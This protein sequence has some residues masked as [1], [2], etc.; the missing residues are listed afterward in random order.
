MEHF[1]NSS[2]LKTICRSLIQNKNWMEVCFVPSVRPHR[3]SYYSNIIRKS[4]NRIKHKTLDGQKSVPVNG[5]CK[6]ELIPIP[7]PD[8][9]WGYFCQRFC[10]CFY[11]NCP[12]NNTIRRATSIRGFHGHAYENRG[13]GLATLLQA[14]HALLC[15]IPGLLLGEMWSV[16]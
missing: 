2:S 1:A 12:L 3:Q 15:P 5:S 10:C 11:F 14:Y 7:P 4:K 8:S 9:S 6:A 16:R 13:E